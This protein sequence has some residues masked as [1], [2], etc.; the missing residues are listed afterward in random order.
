MSRRDRRRQTDVQYGVVRLRCVA[1]DKALG[2]ATVST[3]VELSVFYE[4]AHGPNEDERGIEWSQC[5]RDSCRRRSLRAS[6]AKI[7]AFGA[8]VA[9]G[10]A[11]H[12]DFRVGGR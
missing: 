7:E 8:D 3:L 1:C 4:L 11:R 6:K 12:A 5:P 2:K 9:N 10:R